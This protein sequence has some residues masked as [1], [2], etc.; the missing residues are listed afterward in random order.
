MI[1]DGIFAVRSNS[2]DVYHDQVASKQ[3][4]ASID[5]V[6]ITN[7]VANRGAAGEFDCHSFSKFGAPLC[8]SSD[9]SENNA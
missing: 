4:A 1:C 9:S 5:A 2:D 3:T 7:L 6:I 8:C